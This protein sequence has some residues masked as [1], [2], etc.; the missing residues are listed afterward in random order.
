MGTIIEATAT[1]DGGSSGAL[2]LAD[3]AA[4][5]CLERAKRTSEE[6]NLLINAG[7]YNDKGISE[8]AVASLI[9][10]DIGANPEELPGLG[11]GTFSFDVRNGGCGMLSGIQ[12]ADGLLASGTVKLGMVVASDIDP[13]PGVSE[14][15]GFPAVGGAVLLS[16]DDSPAGFTAFRNATFPQFAGLFQS[17][18]AWQDDTRPGHGDQGR[19]V[20]CV[21]IAESYADRALECAESTVREA[22][23]DGVVDLG[24]VDLLV[25]TASVPGFA[26][27]LAQR[28]GVSAARVAS[29]SQALAGAHTAA[30]ASALE[31]VQP[32]VGSTALFV[33]VGAGI[34]V[35]AALYRG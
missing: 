8:P 9:Q 6:V 27:A 26:V 29:P 30:L 14:G 7:I 2:E 23:A 3:A 4:R 1:A 28:L 16:T 25:A 10:E 32:K 35:V 34:T 17:S 21:D 5:L 15:F 11:Q 18:V 24:E 19:N 31:S 20:L 13:D 22:V 33:C 12:L